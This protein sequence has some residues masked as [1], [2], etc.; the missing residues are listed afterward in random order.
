MVADLSKARITEAQKRHLPKD[1]FKATHANKFIG[2]GNGA[3]GEYLRLCKEA[4]YPVNYGD[5]SEND[6]VFISANGKRK[7]RL[8][9]D[10]EEIK[11]AC[12][13]GASFLT[14]A[15]CRRP[16]GGNPYNIGEQEVADYLRS[17]LYQEHRTSRHD[18]SLWR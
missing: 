6:I 16:E 14:D 8:S 2:R 11:R 4:K 12:D 15:R 7:G 13:T 18:V 1:Q 9:P 17:R 3:T 10:I 5:Y